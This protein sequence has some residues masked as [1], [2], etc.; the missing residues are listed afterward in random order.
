M[1]R[2]HAAVVGIVLVL[3]AAAPLATHAAS[4][5][6]SPAA[7]T[8]AEPTTAPVDPIARD[9][10]ADLIEGWWH[11]LA[12]SSFGST[13]AAGA[14]TGDAMAVVD[15]P[16]GQAARYDPAAN[17]WTELSS[18]PGGFDPNSPWIWTGTELVLFD[19]SSGSGKGRALDPATDTW[20]TLAEGPL[21]E[22]RVAVWADGRAIVG[23]DDRSLAAYDVATD[24]WTELALAPGAA[25]LYGLYWTGDE[26]LATTGPRGLG[27]FT[28]ASLD[29]ESQTWS[30]PDQ[31]PVS[32]F[33]TS[34]QWT[35]SELL[36]AGG[37]PNGPD[38][39]VNAAY[40]PATGV[41]NERD[42]DCPATTDIGLWDGDLLIDVLTD[43]DGQSLP[44]VA[45]D[46]A[47][48]ECRQLRDSW[49]RRQTLQRGRTPE[50]TLLTGDEIVMWSR[51]GGDLTNKPDRHF[52]AFTPAPTPG[53]PTEPQVDSVR[54]D[55]FEL[56]I[57]TP[58]SV[59]NVGEP[60]DIET[61][62]GYV[63]SELETSVT[64]SGSGL[65][66]FR[67]E[68]LDD[69]SSWGSGWTADLRRYEVRSGD[70]Q[71]I[72]ISGG[73]SPDDRPFWVV[74]DGVRGL[75]PPA[76]RYHVAA[77]LRYGHPDT[78][79]GGTRTAS[80]WIDVVDGDAAATG[81]A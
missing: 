35:G 78:G 6:P 65:V 34:P 74:R 45:L 30:E 26:V 7:S 11:Q 14:W 9:D 16:S 20:R 12:R 18:G 62:L 71:T 55:I 53:D 19:G 44:P 10:G 3:A 57:S 39:V 70:V 69:R 37:R 43:R 8:I 72:Q 24:T 29:L 50:L 58:R 77:D 49:V 15:I 81:G 61:T 38:G 23:G 76:G 5:Q 4:P 63:G 66:F 68:Q 60:I 79:A 27:R 13:A 41:W 48:G 31:G 2:L 73:L 33:W 75:R 42:Y 47:T 32:S 51:F 25:R 28:I 22:P 52:V 80:L 64:G 46:P 17:R 1:V 40:D 56:T 36:F 67:I 21:K 54:D 59:W